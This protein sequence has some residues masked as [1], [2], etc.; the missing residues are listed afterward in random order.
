[1][2]MPIMTTAEVRGQY[3][4]LRNIL[5]E[6]SAIVGSDYRRWYDEMVWRT[7]WRERLDWV[8]LFWPIMSIL[9]RPR[10][11]RQLWKKLERC[12][13]CRLIVG[14][15]ENVGDI[16]DDARKNGNIVPIEDVARDAQN[17]LI[18]RKP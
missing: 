6:P 1:M 2:K 12:L 17:R 8:L 10:W 13:F 18:Y 9:Y 14:R 16:I 11:L 15:R 3:V 7:M 4:D 5:D